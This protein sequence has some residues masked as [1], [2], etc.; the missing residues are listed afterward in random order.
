MS[1]TTVPEGFLLG[2]CN[3]LLDISA[4]VPKEFIDKYEA[5]HGSACL[6]SEKQLPLY[7]ELV[8]NYPVKYIAGGATQNVMRVFQWMNQSSVP[9]AVFLGC[10]GDDEFGSIMRDTV[11]KD[12]LKVIYQVT[13]EKPTGTCAVLVCDNER[14]LVAN[15]GAAEKY[16]FEHYQSEQVQIAVKQA[17]MY[18]ISGFFLTV[19]FESV[20]ATAQH[21]CENDKIF[22]FNL[23]AP[24]IIQFFN[25]K[26]M[27][28]LPY[29]DY[30]FGNEEEARTFATSMKWDLTDVAEIAA[31]TSLL[32]KKNE[33][34][35]RIVVFTQGADDVCIGINGQSHKVPV[36]KI[37][38]E[39]IVDTNGAGDSFVGGFLSY[40]AKGYPID[41]CVKAGIYTS[42]T[43]IQYE[44]CTYPEK[45]DLT[46]I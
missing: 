40:L 45:P 9:T 21:A 14:A 44:G 18:Y 20:L 32:E 46:Q 30:L 34:R 16:S 26:L 7:G 12:G 11:T 4:V 27:Q 38:K 25:D 6:A 33:K 5:P 31:K 19:S 35:Q 42:S 13:K 28:I 10:V 15:L 1:A 39:M 3:P 2:M 17:Q 22:S 43:I 36:R 29:A 41:D 23:S 24:F 8:S 37:S